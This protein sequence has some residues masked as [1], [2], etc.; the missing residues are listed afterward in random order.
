MRRYLLPIALFLV[1]LPA[2]ATAPSDQYEPFDRQVV[3]IVD[4]KTGLTWERNLDSGSHNAVSIN[5]TYDQMA[6]AC[7]TQLSGGGGRIPTIKEL[8]TLLDEAPYAQQIKGKIVATYIDS[9]AFQNMAVDKPFWSSTPVVG[10]T[11]QVWTLDFGTG[12]MR[13]T[14]KTAN[15]AVRCVR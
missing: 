10:T 12:D 14:P 6:F 4:Q 8:L 15:A 1:A 13:A 3:V 5:G 2:G 9:Y 7:P 11:D